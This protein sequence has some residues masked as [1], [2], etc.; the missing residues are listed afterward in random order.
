MMF[1]QVCITQKSVF[2]EFSHFFVAI[3][4]LIFIGHLYQHLFLNSF[5]LNHTSR[6]SSCKILLF[7][8]CMFKF[9]TWQDFPIFLFFFFFSLALTFA[10]TALLGFQPSGLFFFALTFAQ[11]ALLGFQP[12]RLSLFSFLFGPSFCLDC[13]FRF[14]A[15][16]AFF[17]GSFI[18]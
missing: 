4:S 3:F 10:Q 11:T 5:I 18:S 12:S 13:P 17:F 8:G 14:S 2:D 6:L 9:P 16:R 15:Q 1:P 7:L